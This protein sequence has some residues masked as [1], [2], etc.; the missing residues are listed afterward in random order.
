M[1]ERMIACVDQTP[2]PRRLALGSDAYAT[3]HAQ[4]VARL[5]ELETQKALAFSTDL[6]NQ[7][8]TH[9]V[10]AALDVVV[11][12]DVAESPAAGRA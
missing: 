6:P 4:L 7:D 10:A 1:V 2:A 5:A 3:M 9:A 8:G 11:K 12:Q